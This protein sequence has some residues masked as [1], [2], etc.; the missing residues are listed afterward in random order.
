[1]KRQTIYAMLIVAFAMASIMEAQAQTAESGVSEARIRRLTSPDDKG[2]TTLRFS[3]AATGGAQM[4]S[5]SPKQLISPRSPQEL[6]ALI[7]EN[8]TPPALK[9]TALKATAVP[10]AS[11]N[12]SAEKL[13]SELSPEETT[14]TMSKEPS[15]APALPTQ[16]NAKEAQ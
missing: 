15:P 7:F 10:Q 1:M 9:G 12:L 5:V 11:R 3:P 14:K 13:P 6:R 8:Y 16:G 2:N 4:S